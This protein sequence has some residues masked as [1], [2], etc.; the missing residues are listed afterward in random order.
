MEC[1]RS[2]FA[3]L[4]FKIYLPHNIFKLLH[5]KGPFFNPFDDASVIQTTP[6]THQ[7]QQQTEDQKTQR[8]KRR[9]VPSLLFNVTSPS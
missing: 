4:F 1:Q 6:T 9:V 8:R 2:V 3:S 5:L 7:N